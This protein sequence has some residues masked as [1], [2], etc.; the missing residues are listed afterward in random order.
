MAKAM[1]VQSTICTRVMR[2]VSDFISLFFLVNS[3]GCLVIFRSKS[4]SFARHVPL[5]HLAPSSLKYIL[6]RFYKIIK[7]LP[8]YE[9]YRSILTRRRVEFITEFYVYI[10]IIDA[11]AIIQVMEMKKYQRNGGGG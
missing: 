10:A 5:S 8:G 7:F 11:K 3:P 9:N 6:C 1:V 2:V 4:Q